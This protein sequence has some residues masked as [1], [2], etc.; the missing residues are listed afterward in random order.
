[1]QQSNTSTEGNAGQK[2][3]ALVRKWSRQLILGFLVFIIGSV[4]VLVVVPVVSPAIGANMADFL[5]TVFGP[6]PVALLES[7]SFQLHDAMSSN[8]YHGDTPQISWNRQNP[9]SMQESNSSRQVGIHGGAAMLAI[10]GS[11]VVSA[12][13]Q[14]G[15]QPYGPMV[16]GANVLAR[17]LIAKD[18]RRTYT[19]IALVRI[20]LSK[21]QLHVMP[22]YLEPSHSLQ[23]V[24][25]IPNLGMVPAN[26]R[27]KLIAAFNG[28]FKTINGHFGMIVNGLTLV[29]PKPNVAT[30][31]V[32]HDGHVQIGAWGKDIF[33]STDMVALRQNCPPLIDAGELNSDLSY[34]NRNEW[35]YTGNSDITWRTGLGISQD[36][37]YLIYAV[38]NGTSALTLAQALKD[39]GA[40]SAMQL[41][42]NQYYA[43]FE[44]YQ[45]DKSSNSTGF[46]LVAERLLNKMI[47]EV[48]IYLTP[49][50]RDFFYLTD[51]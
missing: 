10:N 3:K 47:N 41:D 32:Y 37:R 18:P 5:R 13:P 11:D 42:I 40:Y 34:N 27:A 15:W 16:N 35:G 21:L 38:G 20:D 9:L 29:Q 19:G 46:K 24:R 23:V 6:Q 7:V 51:R 31:A 25:A 45:S 4:A 2:G 12:V 43:H 8:L 36:G 39:A 30:V 33:P 17:V 28:G 22:G 1:V 48:N 49:N 50:A 26:D 14:I 44:T